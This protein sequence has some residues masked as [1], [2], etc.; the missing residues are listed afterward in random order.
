MTMASRI[1]VMDHGKL[2][3]VDTPDRIYEAPNSTYVADFI[4]DVNIIEGRVSKSDGD[5]AELAWAEGHSPIRGMSGAGISNGQGG[6]FA[7]RPEK[8]A[9]AT[10]EPIDVHNRISGEVED[11][12]YLGNISTY[13]VRLANGALVKSQTV[14]TRRIARRGITW[15]DKVWLSWTDTAGIVLAG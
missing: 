6:A 11:I 8:I 15:N 2:V 9:I 3:Q 5:A 12:A 4:G 7:I 1:A 14:N 13:Y 10:D